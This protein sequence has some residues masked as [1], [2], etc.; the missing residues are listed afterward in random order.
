MGVVRGEYR[1]VSLCP[2]CGAPTAE[3]KYELE[4][5]VGVDKPVIKITYKLECSVC[6][7]KES[8]KA[9]MP[10][11]AAYRLRHLMEPPPKLLLEKMWLAHSAAV[12]GVSSG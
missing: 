6:G 4:G 3:F 2:D 12:K 5:D 7:Y 11:H 8:M 9:S 1:G 10:L